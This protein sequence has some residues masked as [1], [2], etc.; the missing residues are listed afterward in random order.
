MGDGRSASRGVAGRIPDLPVIADVIRTGSG[1]PMA[2]YGAAF[3]EAMDRFGAPLSS[4][5]LVPRWLPQ[6]PEVETALR[7]GARMADV[8]CGAARA[9]TESCTLVLVEYP[10][11]PMPFAPRRTCRPRDCH[12]R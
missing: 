2:R 11:M 4:G 1:V 8:G 6:L 10:K 5:T 9:V 12:A 7:Q 3:A